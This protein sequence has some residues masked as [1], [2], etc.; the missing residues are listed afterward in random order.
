M[1][2]SPCKCCVRPCANCGFFLPP[3]NSNEFRAHAAGARNC[4]F[5]YVSHY[6]KILNLHIHVIARLI[7]EFLT[8]D[9]VCMG[10]RST[11]KSEHAW[12][13]EYGYNVRYGLRED[14]E[15]DDGTWTYFRNGRWW[16]KGAKQFHKQLSTRRKRASRRCL[17]LSIE[18][19]CDAYRSY[20]GAKMGYYIGDIRKEWWT[21]RPEPHWVTRYRKKTGVTYPY[22][23]IDEEYPPVYW[24]Y[25]MM[26]AFCKLKYWFKVPLSAVMHRQTH[27]SWK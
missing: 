26:V 2:N 1:P 15:L 11:S 27:G 16:R 4:D 5:S 3:T 17:D 6:V 20:K 24:K 12:N 13:G 22:Q 25:R 23:L 8:A 18:L 7:T 19:Y 21:R 9:V 14:G 10:C